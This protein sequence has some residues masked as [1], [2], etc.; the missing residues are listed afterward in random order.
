MRSWLV[1]SQFWS[2]CLR[3]NE[4]LVCCVVNLL[5]YSLPDNIDQQMD[6]DTGPYIYVIMTNVINNSGASKI[7]QILLAAYVH[8]QITQFKSHPV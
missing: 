7:L 4:C 2:G 5:C 8:Q 3:D 1:Y 6:T